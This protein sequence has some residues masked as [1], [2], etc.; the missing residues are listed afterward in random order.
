MNLRELVW[1]LMEALGRKQVVIYNFKVTS[2]Q[3]IVVR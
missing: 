2:D 3:S 1:K